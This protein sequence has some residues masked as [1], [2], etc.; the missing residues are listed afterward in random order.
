MST[1]KPQIDLSKCPVGTRLRLR[2]GHMATLTEVENPIIDEQPIHVKHDDG[3]TC[4]H[5]VGGCFWSNKLESAGDI[6]AIL[7][8][9]KAKKAGKPKTAGKKP[10]HLDPKWLEGEFDKQAIHRVIKLLEGL[11][12]P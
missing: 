12:N 10:D 7:P 8:P 2:N 11:L 5:T 4:F 9:A 1:K 3:F 6:V